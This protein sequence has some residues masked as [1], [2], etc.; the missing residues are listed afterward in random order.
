MDARLRSIED[1]LG[2][3]ERDLGIIKS[4]LESL[5]GRWAQIVFLL[6]ILLPIYSIMVT[7]LWNTVHR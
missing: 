4:R 5:P 2:A 6:A 1:R 3:I 7:L